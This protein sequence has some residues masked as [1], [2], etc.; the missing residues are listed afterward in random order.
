MSELNWQKYEPKILTQ[1]AHNFFAIRVAQTISDL[2]PT[3]EKIFNDSLLTINGHYNRRGYCVGYTLEYNK[4]PKLI[5]SEYFLVLDYVKKGENP[6]E[7]TFPKLGSGRKTDQSICL[8]K[9][10]NYIADRMYVF[11]YRRKK[12]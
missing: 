11:I 9:F 12:D 4:T 7:I 8:A 3:V 6:K 5:H 2:T 1:V 10:G